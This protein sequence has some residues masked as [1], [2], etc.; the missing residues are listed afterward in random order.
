MAMLAEPRRRQKWLISPRGKPL[1]E[2]AD[3]FG[4]K[5][6]M[7]MGWSHGK[8]LGATESGE[9]EFVKVN[10]KN[11]KMGI[12]CEDRSDQWT[13]HETDFNSLLKSLAGQAN[14]EDETNEQDD[15]GFTMPRACFGGVEKKQKKKKKKLDEL[16]GES[17]EEKSKNSR[18]R[19][20]YKKFTRGKDTSRYSEK[21]LANI[22]GK[23]VDE[24]DD[25]EDVK[26]SYGIVYNVKEDAKKNK[27]R[28]EQEDDVKNDELKY[29]IPTIYSGTSTVDY[30]KQKMQNKS[31]FLAVE[32]KKEE[33]VSEPEDELTIK[34]EKMSNEIIISQI[35]EEFVE[36][37]IK[38][39]K[40]NKKIITETEEELITIIKSE[41][42]MEVEIKD[43]PNIVEIIEPKI[44][45]E[46][47]IKTEPEEEIVEPKI[48]KEKKNK[49]IIV[50]TEVITIIE[51]EEPIK[52][53]KSK[54]RKFEEIT[55]PIEIQDDPIEIPTKKSKKNKNKEIVSE[56]LIVEIVD[57]PPKKKKKQSIEVEENEPEASTI[58]QISTSNATV[59]QHLDP[60][61]FKN[62]NLKNISG[63][64][65][66]SNIEL[67]VI[68]RQRRLKP[69]WTSL[70]YGIEE[71]SAES[72]IST[73]KKKTKKNGGKI[74][75][76]N[77]FT[78]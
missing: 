70:K 30:F 35:K 18:S 52:K 74:T 40:K 11:D 77:L 31:S 43:E 37:T 3:N 25:I 45:K 7:K 66:T 1:H 16:S 58:Y 51:S 75:T 29:G 34:K 15:D 39:E 6:L 49:K 19:L 2:D 10:F 56:P 21:D 9:K 69:H 59:L 44:K 55:D 68:E 60:E 4:N 62:A 22:F 65:L 5:M 63:Y 46:K 26:I 73:Q 72:V 42:K 8:G 54:K 24:K 28:D 67:E 50:E 17:L 47:K 48:K 12:G 53:K 61:G 57:S 14:S 23:K 36:P 32:I 76:K 71:N 27:E 38:K 13:Q 20:H 64:G 78:F 41:I 33:N